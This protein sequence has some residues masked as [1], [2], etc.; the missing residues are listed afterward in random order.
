MNLLAR[1]AQRIERRFPKPG[2]AGSIPVASTTF[3]FSRVRVLS[4]LRRPRRFRQN[5]VPRL[6]RARR[7]RRARPARRFLRFLSLDCLLVLLLSALPLFD[8]FGVCLGSSLFVVP[9]FVVLETVA[10]SAHFYH[11]P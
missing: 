9:A 3:G 11:V 7:V 10:A 6:R 4:P 1:V 2:V 8:V 5:R